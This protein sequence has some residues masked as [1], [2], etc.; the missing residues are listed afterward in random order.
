MNLEFLFDDEEADL[1]SINRYIGLYVSENQLAEFEIEPTVLGK[2]FEQTPAPK[3]GVDGQPYTLR[4]F[5]QNN[6]NG[7]E[8]PVN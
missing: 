4:T 3:P 7:I 5:V 2:I 6:P 1:Y 8:I